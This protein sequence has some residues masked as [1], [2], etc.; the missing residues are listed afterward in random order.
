MGK[1]PQYTKS[2]SYFGLSNSGL[3]VR[4][5]IQMVSEEA[6]AKNVGVRDCDYLI[7][8]NFMHLT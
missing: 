7:D 4:V 2:E 8:E 5:P 6:P 3:H 1:T